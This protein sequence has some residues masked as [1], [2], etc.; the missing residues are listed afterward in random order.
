MPS[1]APH[2]TRTVPLFLLPILSVLLVLPTIASFTPTL[3]PAVILSSLLLLSPTPV[4]SDVENPPIPII[5]ISPLRGSDPVKKLE[6][7]SKIKSACEEIGFM[8][9]TNHGVKKDV[10]ENAWETVAEFFD[11]PES[12]KSSYSAM[13]EDYPYG[14]EKGEV[15]AAGKDLED[16]KKLST[17]PDMKETFTVGPSNPAS[18][19]PSRILPSSP[20]SFASSYNSYYTEMENLADNLLSSF[21]LALSLPSDWFVPKTSHHLSALRS[22]NYPDQAGVTP[23]PGQLRAGAHTDYG[24]LTILKSG[25]PGLQVAKDV[26]GEPRWVNVPHVEDG[27][28]INLG[29]LMKRWTNDRWSSTLHRVVNPPRDGRDHRR[30]SIAF[31]HN[32]NGDE[33]VETIESCRGEGGSK[34]EPIVAKDFLMMKHLASVKGVIE[35][36]G[37]EEL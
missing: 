25:G 37:K 33:V 11:L 19:M 24:S 3:Y 8:V 31:F 18:G 34:Y 30:Q 32:I 7:V 35:K 1:K 22:L 4:L 36:D 27:F 23:E 10:V 15:L 20:P 21:A 12:E 26:G 29:D 28:V 2:P 6:T 17:A 14:Y 13:S 5:D 9:V 16:G